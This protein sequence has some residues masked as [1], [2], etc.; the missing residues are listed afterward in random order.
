MADNFISHE[1][2]NGLLEVADRKFEKGILKPA[3]IGQGKGYNHQR[4]IRSDYIL[5]IQ[6]DTG[7]VKGQAFLALV[8]GL[9]GYLN[10][11]CFWLARKKIVGFSYLCRYD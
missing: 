7:F 11:T 2:M 6:P 5:W 8:N 4:S 1:L 3:G 10:R 9:A